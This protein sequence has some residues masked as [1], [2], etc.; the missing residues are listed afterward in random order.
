VRKF[1]VNGRVHCTFNQVRFNDDEDEG[2]GVRFGRLSSSSYNMQAQPVRH[3]EYGKIWR[4]VYV[5]DEDADWAC[6]DWSQQEPRLGV[7]YAEQ[8][9]LPGAKEFADEYRANPDL[10]IHQKLADLSGTL[11]RK[12]VKNYV[13][14][15]LYGMGDAKLCHSLGVPTAWEV[16]SWSKG[17][18]VEVAGPEGQQIIDEF[19]RFAPWIPGLVKKAKYTARKNG[20]VWT[21]GRRR[22]NFIRRPDGSIDR[23]HK[24]FNRVGQGGAADMMKW[25]LVEAER[26]GIEIQLAVHDEFDF[27][28]GDIS[29]AKQ[30]RDIQRSAYAD[31]INVPM[32]VDL[33]IGPNWGELESVP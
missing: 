10:D 30:L 26:C 27:S 15:R 6:S 29:E 12:I 32:K 2:K 14:G 9:K 11:P 3:D 24:A 16:T 22:C 5:A 23:E 17:R 4:A 33:E 28:F 25:A 7:H 31:R 18:M 19:L 13:N 20:C 8:L 21:I 1:E